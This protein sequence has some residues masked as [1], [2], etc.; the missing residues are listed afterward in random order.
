MTTSAPRASSQPCPR[1]LNAYSPIWDRDPHDANMAW[2]RD[3]G[4]GLFIHFGLYSMMGA[5]EWVQFR[6]QVPVGEY[7]TLSNTFTARGFD[8]GLIADLACEAGMKY[9][10]LV[11]CHHEGFCLW[12]SPGEPFNSVR[13]PCGRDLVAELAAACDRRGLGFFTYYTFMLN[14][15]FPRGLGRSSLE[16]AR[17]AY[18]RPQPEYLE[19]SEDAFRQHYVPY[20]QGQIRELLT[21]VRPLAG[22][23]L[24]IIMAYYLR[25]DLVPVE[26]TYKLIRALRPECLLSFKQGATGTEDFGTPEQHFHSLGE[27]FRKNGNLEAAARA[28]EAWAKNRGK[29]NEICATLQKGAWGYQSDAEHLTADE[30]WGLLGH[31]RAHDCNLLANVGPLPDGS[32]HPADIASLRAVGRRLR[33][34]GWPAASEACLPGEKATGAGGA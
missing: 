20:M 10:T 6:R 33:E 25:P 23:W 4:W 31:A 8:A 16:A 15:R 7:A 9:I 12:D 1:Y 17:P 29:H 30:I 5:G 28:D 26:S 3:A 22:M 24:D 32:I 19:E 27:V 21:R 34:R 14:W 18:A 2:F 11:S 13:S